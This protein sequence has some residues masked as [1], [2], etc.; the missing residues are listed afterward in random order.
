MLDVSN[1]K[2][3]VATK[4]ACH[5]KGEVYGVKTIKTVFKLKYMYP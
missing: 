4:T 1:G 5:T 3:S 2:G